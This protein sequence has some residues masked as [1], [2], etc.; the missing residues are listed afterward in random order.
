MTELIDTLLII[1]AWLLAAVSGLVFLF[2]P[3]QMAIY[4]IL[5]SLFCLL[6]RPRPKA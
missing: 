5:L 2:G 1:A 3:V 4:L 6:S